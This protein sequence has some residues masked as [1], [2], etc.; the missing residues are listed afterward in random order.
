MTPSRRRGVGRRKRVAPASPGPR[1]LARVFWP[2]SSGPRLLGNERLPRQIALLSMRHATPRARRAGRFA[3]R[4]AG[5]ISVADAV[6]EG[7]RRTAGCSGTRRC[8]CRRRRPRPATQSS[9]TRAASGFGRL[10]GDG[11]CVSAATAHHPGHAWTAAGMRRP[12]SRHVGA[13][14]RRSSS[15]PLADPRANQDG[16]GE[17]APHFSRSGS[18]RGGARGGADDATHATALDSRTEPRAVRIPPKRRS[19]A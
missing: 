18:P 17:T 12:C 3:G 5:P 9:E 8:S 2:A 10:G 6:P 15:R 14:Q 16:D 7:P 13:V 4:P 19:R 1:L 11:S